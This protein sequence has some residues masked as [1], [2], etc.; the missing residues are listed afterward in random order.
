MQNSVNVALSRNQDQITVNLNPPELG[1]VTIKFIENQN[2][3]SGVLLVE[4]AQI[5]AEM[6]RALPQIIRN[7]EGAGIQ[8]KRIDVEVYDQ[9][10]TN[11]Q[12]SKDHGFQGSF[13][14]QQDS[15]QD[16]S[17]SNHTAS[18]SFKSNKAHINEEDTDS[19]Q[20]NS[21]LGSESINLFA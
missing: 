20:L 16:Q 10:N 8:V 7:L 18:T 14:A 4:K 11:Q 21:A 2:Q 12:A 19:D 17:D 1:R 3:I 6:E 9:N 15:D 5:R 13:S